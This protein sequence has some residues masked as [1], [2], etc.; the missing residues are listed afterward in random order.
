MPHWVAPYK[1]RRSTRLLSYAVRQNHT[2]LETGGE[3]CYLLKR[4]RRAN[5]IQAFASRRADWLTKE[6]TSYTLDPDTGYLRYKL[7]GADTDSVET[8]PDIGTLTT[9]VSASGGGATEVWED[10]VDKHS[11]ISGRNEY[12]FD[13]YQDDLDSDGNSIIDA[14]YVVFNTPPFTTGKHVSFQYGPINPLNN[15]YRMQPIRDNQPV[16]QASLFSFE[17]WEDANARIR[18]QPTPNQFLVAFP[19]ILTNFEV[20]AGGFLQTSVNNYWTSPPPYSPDLVE[21]D[22]V[23]RLSTSQR[24]QITNAT[25]IYVENILVSQQF[26]MGLLDPKS[27]IYNVAVVGS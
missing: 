26:E 7:W 14:V 24:Y 8:Y 23:I 17:Q 27:S 2:L 3:A 6:A 12:A 9:T 10:A 19:G 25:P 18:K 1:T 21:H 16:Y 5:E 15:Q 4:L 20:V 11:F 22:V 13:V